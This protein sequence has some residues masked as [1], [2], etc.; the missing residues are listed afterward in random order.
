VDDD[1]DEKIFSVQLRIFGKAH[2]P[3]EIT[4]M[5]GLEPTYSHALGDPIMSR[6]TGR[7]AGA[8]IRGHLWLLETPNVGT[9]DDQIQAIATRLLSKAAVLYDLAKT[10]EV[11]IVI[12]WGCTRLFV[13]RGISLS[14]STL[15]AVAALG[16]DLD[17][18]V[19]CLLDHVEDEERDTPTA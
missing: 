6:T 14:A 12:A 19:F 9:L 8:R 3:A 1:G 13:G 15:A 11:S 4:A 2:S 18:Q 16:A 10:S 5:L 7:V 17:Y